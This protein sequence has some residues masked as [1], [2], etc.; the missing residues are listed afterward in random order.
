MTH[1]HKE[2]KINLSKNAPKNPNKR[3]IPILTT[4]N[5]GKRVKGEINLKV[6]EWMGL[7]V[8]ALKL[9]NSLPILIVYLSIKLST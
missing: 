5:K 7:I 1:K 9:Q 3:D 4:R 2:I 8:L 6:I